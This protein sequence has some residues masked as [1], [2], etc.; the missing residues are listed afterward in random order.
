MKAHPRN[1]VNQPFRLGYSKQRDSN[2]PFELVLLNHD[3]EESTFITV[4]SGSLISPW[5][6]F[7]IKPSTIFLYKAIQGPINLPLMNEAFVE[8]MDKFT[9]KYACNKMLVPRSFNEFRYELR[10]LVNP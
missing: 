1:T 10:K 8:Y 6:I 7:D 4:S 2:F 5:V 3:I 9:A